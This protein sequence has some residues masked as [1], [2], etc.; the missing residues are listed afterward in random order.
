MVLEGA[1]STLCCVCPMFLRRDSLEG[2]VVFGEG[3]LQILRALVVEDV[4]F[5]WVAFGEKTSVCFNPSVA[6]AGCLSVLDRCSMDGVSVCV[7]KQEDVLVSAT[8][9]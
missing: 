6:N 3:V 8:G 1:Y 7:V 4:E 5:G 9:D 2:D